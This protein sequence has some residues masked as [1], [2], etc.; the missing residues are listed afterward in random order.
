VSP[1]VLLSFMPIAIW[2]ATICCT[3]ICYAAASFR[4]RRLFLLHPFAVFCRCLTSP[5]HASRQHTERLCT[6]PP[7]RK[8][9]QKRAQQQRFSYGRALSP[10]ASSTC[11][12]LS[13]YRSA[14]QHR[15][16]HAAAVKDTEEMYARI[17]ASISACLCGPAQIPT[18][19]PYHGRA[20]FAPF[21]GNT[22]S[23]NERSTPTPTPPG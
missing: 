3:D 22:H 18:S 16:A 13:S 14:A 2:N 20:I 9:R 12:L 7:T 5:L 10:R 23:R 17:S 15:E 19:T 8:V 21:V 4:F 6:S 1:V 11:L